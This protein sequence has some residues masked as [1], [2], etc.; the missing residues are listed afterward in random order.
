MKK[1]YLTLVVGLFLFP[2]ILTSQTVSI[3]G[4]ITRH[5]GDPLSDIE[6]NCDGTVTTDVNGNFEFTDITLNYM[7]DVF[8]SGN[9]DK[10][11]EVTV[12]D[13]LVLQ[14]FI[15]QLTNNISGHQLLA[16]DVNNSAAVTALDMVKIF[17]LALRINETSIQENWIFAYANFIFS[18]PFTTFPP[19]FI[20]VTATDT[21]TDVDF[22]AIKRGDPAISSDYMPAPPAAPSPIFTIINESFQ[23][24]DD[25]QF[26]VTVEDFS[27]ISGCQQTFKWD[28]NVL[29]FQSVEGVS[30]LNVN[31]NDAEISQGLLPTLSLMNFLQ[32]Q[33]GEVLMTLN[34]KALADVPSMTEVLFFS[35]EITAKQVVWQ[36]PDDL[37]LFIVDATYINGEGTTGMANA[38]KTLESFQI[39][40]NPVE[41]KFYVKALLLD[42]EDVEISIVNVLGQ[43]VFS[44]NFDQKEIL[45]EIGFSEFPSGTYFLSL[46][47][48]DGIQTESFV[49]K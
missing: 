14:Q 36:N 4:Q 16:C 20:N 31:I 40:P 3:S 41:D 30:G 8:A 6:V 22:I 10:Y 7:C 34:F 48:A 2:T 32:I 23:V 12:L 33:D 46:K 11:E 45:L 15:L 27:N 39:F 29:E 35:D 37:E 5:N 13:A 21:I 26:E 42:A 25:V 1:I 43:S 44:K 38:P 19:T 17:Q 47:K 24:G 49:K 9:F 18:F 28:T